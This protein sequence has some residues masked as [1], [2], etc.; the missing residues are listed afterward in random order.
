MSDITR[1]LVNVF[2]ILMIEI[3]KNSI[4]IITEN[5]ILTVKESDSKKIKIN[6][7]TDKCRDSLW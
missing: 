1:K 5:I 2:R 3:E 4:E 6:A 7:L